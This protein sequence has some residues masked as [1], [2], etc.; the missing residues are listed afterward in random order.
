[1]T[2]SLSLSAW[3]VVPGMIAGLGIVG[4]SSAES[5]TPSPS[6]S[7]FTVPHVPVLTVPSF[8]QVSAPRRAQLHFWLLLG[9]T[10]FGFSWQ[11]PLL[12]GHWAS[13]VQMMV[14][15]LLQVPWDRTAEVAPEQSP[16]QASPMPSPS[17]S[18]WPG[19][20][21]RT[22]LSLRSLMP[23]PSRSEVWSQAVPRPP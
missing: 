5:G 8:W 18:A 7:S 13:V 19:F 16:S 10:W 20:G 12:A 1:P 22:Q 3:R 15:V 17:W 2:P 9:E 23:S 6:R 21:V 14:F 11:T 4:Q